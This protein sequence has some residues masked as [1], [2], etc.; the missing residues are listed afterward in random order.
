VREQTVVELLERD[1][2]L[3]EADRLLAQARAGNGAALLVE[4]PAGIG[5][6]ALIRA[7]RARAQQEGLRVLAARG[8]EL[9]REFSFGVVR[10][11]FEPVLA[12]AGPAQRATLLA[13]AAGLS[14]PAIG[15]LDEGAAVV[16][17][18][19]VDPSFAVLHGLY[20]LT[21]N[22]AEQ[23]PVLLAVD[24]AQ[25]ADIAS[26][27]FLG[28]LA[29]RMEESP[30]LLATGVRPYEP[31][32][33]GELLAA[34]DA[35]AATRTLR[36]AP[37]SEHASA[38]LIR[39]RLT[40]EPGP[41]FA[42]AAHRAAGGNPQLIRELL[43]ALAAEGVEPTAEGAAYVADLRADRIAASVLA[44]LARLGEDALRV[45][46]AT[47]VLG[48]ASEPHMVAELAELPGDESGRLVESLQALEILDPGIRLGFVH[49]LVRTA[50][51]NDFAPGPR[52]EMHRRAA[53]LLA[54]AGKDMQ[55]VAA[56]LVAARPAGDEWTVERLRAAAEGALSRGAP[57]AAVSYL[58]RALA[59]PPPDAARA[60]VLVGLGRGY[61]ML[62][63]PRAGIRALSQAL[64]LTQDPRRRGEIGRI[65][66]TMLGVSRAAARAVEM[67]DREL[68]TLPESER[69]LGL[70][71][72]SDID[73]MSF[74]SLS[75]KQA[76]DGRGRHFDDPA[77]PS[78]LASAAMVASIYE[79]PAERA[80]DLAKRAWADGLLLEREGPDAPAVWMVAC[81]LLYAHSLVR[82]VAVTD[83]WSTEASR[84]GSLRA[85]SIA[86][87]IRARAMGWR[88][89]LAEAEADARA[90]LHGMP[91]AIGFGPSS[92]ADAL[93]EQ[94]RLDEAERALALGARAHVEV[95]WSFFYPMLL[96]SRGRLAA[97]RGR[98]ADARDH[99]MESSRLGEEWG[100]ATPGPWQW[101]ADLAEA[102]LMLGEGA[103]AQ[104][105][106]EGEV[107]LAREFGSDR[108]LG[109]ALRL[110]GLA[111]GP[112]GAL[113]LLADAVA[114]LDR[115]EARLE[116]ARALVELGAA[117]RRAKRPSDAR[118]PLRD[119][120][121]LARG[122]GAVPLA[123]RAHEELTATG[124]RPRKIVRAGVDALT[125]SE[126]RV[127]RMA[128]DGMANKEIAQSLF[129]TVRTVEAHLHHA[130]QKLDISSRGELAPA[131]EADRRA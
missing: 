79:G 44:R 73:A 125:A 63:D 111:A 70:R 86:A 78:L 2:E 13:D 95:E 104:G 1:A 98:L 91:E 17:S 76:T 110:A 117:L 92:L 11:L 21:V 94:G 68:V 108:A 36:L 48:D 39:T 74:F 120:L 26:L 71:M 103:K 62:R 80:I 126:R 96:V 38:E 46:R 102:L 90:F 54:A 4:G 124:A 85:F 32:A 67:L 72:E 89:E 55:S 23:S 129:V 97:R 123:E 43:A 6:S 58:Q 99:L 100:V 65:L 56:Q 47:A 59:E 109:I 37:L 112:D 22:L 57:D 66:I 33:A 101:R 77:N 93:I 113:D 50:V 12:S 14:E 3:N 52:D 5:K 24:D 29:G 30:I 31:R 61:A 84:R 34:L 7:I 75:A 40:V 105:L 119:G 118:E 127:A 19:T 82:C 10:Q 20:W 41:G 64:E 130:Y 131:L 15:G 60:E 49:P 35:E 27:R 121:A 25:W 28:Y 107:A 115:S 106:I 9:E 88:G 87:S 116:H 83:A 42:E 51:Y 45:A 114:V 122:C 8:A 16:G 53:H 128:A 69:E 81:A 18:P